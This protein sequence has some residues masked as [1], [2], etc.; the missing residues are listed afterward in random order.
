MTQAVALMT[1]EDVL[2]EILQTQDKHRLS[3]LMWDT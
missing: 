1:F 2:S 3:P